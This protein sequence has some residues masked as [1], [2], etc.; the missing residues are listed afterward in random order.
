MGHLERALAQV[1]LRLEH[2]RLLVCTHAH[3]DHYG[4]AATIV[5][6][7]GCELWMHPNYE[8]MTRARRG[9]RGGAGPADRGRPPERRPRASRCARYA[10]RAAARAG[11]AGIIEPDRELV[12]GV[13]VQTDLG[14]WRSTRRRATR[15]RTSASTSRSGGC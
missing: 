13:E 5:E 1:S 15:R 8:H 4:Q 7:A 14:T 9:P 10:R 6:R 2:V 3:S 12:P 11:I